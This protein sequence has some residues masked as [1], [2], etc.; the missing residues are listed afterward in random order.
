MNEKEVL[1][2]DRKHKSVL[3]KILQ[4]GI[5]YWIK[6]V[7]DENE[8]YELLDL[9]YTILVVIED[10]FSLPIVREISE[11]FPYTKLVYVVEE[12]YPYYDIHYHIKS[13]VYDSIEFETNLES[14][15]KYIKDEYR[16]N[17][18]IQE[19]LDIAW[20]NYY[21]NRSILDYD[22]NDFQEHLNA[23][24]SDTEIAQYV[25]AKKAQ[26]HELDSVNLYDLN[27]SIIFDLEKLSKAL[28]NAIALDAKESFQIYNKKITS[29]YSIFWELPELLKIPFMQYVLGFNNYLKTVKNYNKKIFIEDIEKGIQLDLRQINKEDIGIVKEWLSQYL[30]YLTTK[31]EEINIIFEGD[32]P[33]EIKEYF[34]NKLSLDRSSFIQSIELQSLIAESIGDDLVDY[35]S[36]IEKK[37]L[38]THIKANAERELIKRELQKLVGAHESLRIDINSMVKLFQKLNKEQT[39]SIKKILKEVKSIDINTELS[40]ADVNKIIEEAKNRISNADLSMLNNGEKKGLIDDLDR[41]EIA[42]KHKLNYIIPLGFVNYIGEIEISHKEKWPRTW[43]EW[44]RLFI[45]KE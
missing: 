23:N 39:K 38:E 13:Q 26:D 3:W 24:Y 10:G 32:S 44:V 30:S 28:E 1:V 9:G 14:T 25:S 5:S 18:F 34:L 6:L 29:A 36:K 2:F 19:F 21:K 45:K 8:L 41:T 37:L 35:L 15:W 22:N 31:I 33:T 40:E 16:D 43:E 42:L 20:D 4:D 27:H 11:N 7:Q 17:K 12:D